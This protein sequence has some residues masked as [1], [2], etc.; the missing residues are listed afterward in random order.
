[1]FLHSSFVGKNQHT[2]SKLDDISTSPC[3]DDIEK[4]RVNVVQER[5]PQE[6]K[7]TAHDLKEAMVNC[8]REI[9]H[10]IVSH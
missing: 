6:S 2:P 1:M 10:T 7:F 9:V 4:R 5:N 8:I 3:E